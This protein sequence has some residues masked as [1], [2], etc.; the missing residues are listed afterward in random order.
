M[1]ERRNSDRV[2]L[3][4]T[5]V[6]EL[7]GDY[8]FAYRALNISDEGIFLEGKICAS[9]QEPFSSISFTLPNGVALK[10]LTARMVREERKGPRRGAAYEFLNLDENSRLELRKFIY[11]N[12]LKGT[13]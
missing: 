5:H 1:Q 10:N 13:A 2:Y 11:E 6:K 3:H 12:L 4:Q 9:D 7:N 8:Q